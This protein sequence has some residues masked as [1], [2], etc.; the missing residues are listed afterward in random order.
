MTT[1]AK[2]SIVCSVI[3]ILLGIAAIYAGTK[4]LALL[5][6]LAMLLWYGAS[7]VLGR[8]QN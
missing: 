6:P 3:L 2:R 8:R 5:I 7:P 1:T 4:S